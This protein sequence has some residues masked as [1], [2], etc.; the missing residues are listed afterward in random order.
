MKNNHSPRMNS[1]TQP[2]SSIPE[3]KIPMPL[4]RQERF[5]KGPISMPWLEEA[6]KLSGKALHVAIMLW[7]LA[8]MRR[9]LVVDI[10]LSRMV[11][12]GVHRSSASRGLKALE[13]AGLVTVFRSPGRKPRVT[14]VSTKAPR[15]C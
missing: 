2:A 5:L 10:N 14:L 9:A 3:R 4:R 7:H 6:G 15:R 8:G 12:M 13:R 11:S 1:S